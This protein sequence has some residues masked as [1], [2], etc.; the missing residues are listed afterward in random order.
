MRKFK[1]KRSFIRN[2]IDSREAKVKKLS[3]LEKA[4]LTLRQAKKK[5]IAQLSD[6]HLKVLN[7]RLKELLSNRENHKL[8]VAEFDNLCTAERL[9]C[10]QELYQFLSGAEFNRRLKHWRIEDI[11]EAMGLK[12]RRERGGRYKEDKTFFYKH[13]NLIEQAVKKAASKYGV[14]SFEKQ[15]ST[16]AKKIFWH[17]SHGDPLAL[18]RSY[19]LGFAQIGRDL[20]TGK[21]LRYR[22]KVN[23]F[24]AK[25][26][27]PRGADYIVRLFKS[28]NGDVEKTK[29]AYNA[30]RQA[31][32]LAHKNPL[33]EQALLY[34]QKMERDY[35]SLR[36]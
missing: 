5:G 33:K 29:Q 11:C 7:Q 25:E 2:E 16:L 10:V 34:S 21:D 8:S 9:N 36:N 35:K 24:N 22:E 17:E 19:H 23:P 18:S 30:G 20:F 15:L 32:L 28:F 14:H 1:E 13:E 26:A 4:E 3:F 27:I 12:R 31:V 6:K